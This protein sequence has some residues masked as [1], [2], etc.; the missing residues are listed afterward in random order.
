MKLNKYQVG[1]Q[2]GIRTL[3]NL[4]RVKILI[5]YAKKQSMMNQPI[6]F[7]LDIAI[8]FDKVLKELLLKAIQKKINNSETKG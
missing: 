3:V 2:A 5:K 6:L 8:A 7:A 4:L 1:F